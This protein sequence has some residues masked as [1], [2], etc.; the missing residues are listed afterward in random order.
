MLRRH[1][2]LLRLFPRCG[3][4]P[5]RLLPWRLRSFLRLGDIPR[6]RLLSLWRF[7]CPGAFCGRFRLRL[8]PRCRLG[9]PRVLLRRLCRFGGLAYRSRFTCGIRL[10]TPRGGVLRAVRREAILH[11]RLRRLRRYIRLLRL[12]IPP[13]LLKSRLLRGRSPAHLLLWRTALLFTLLG[14]V[15]A[16]LV[17]LIL[18]FLPSRLGLG[19]LLLPAV[20][21]LA[22]L[23]RNLLGRFLLRRLRLRRRRLCGSLLLGSLLLGRNVSRMRLRRFLFSLLSRGTRLFFTSLLV[24]RKVFSGIDILLLLLRLWRF[25][26]LLRLLRMRRSGWLD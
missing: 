3:G 13:I 15:I 7:L 26:R 22:V 18:R 21:R 2:S 25:H 20:L 23:H 11:G 17:S 1:L 14:I 10:L 9:L 16:L 4:L 19:I 24:C 12:A 5:L 6:L 8:I